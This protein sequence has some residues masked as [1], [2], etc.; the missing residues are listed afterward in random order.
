M[1][2]LKPVTGIG[3][4]L[5]FGIGLAACNGGQSSLAPQEIVNS[6]LQEA[7]EPLSYYGEYT[8]RIDSDESDATIKEWVSEDGKR[9]I[10]M[11]DEGDGSRITGVNDGESYTMYDE[12]TNTAMVMA[13]GKELQEAG[14]QTPR[15]QAERMLEMVKDTHEL[16]VGDEGKIAGRDTY[17]VIATAKDDKSLLGDQ[18]IWIDKETWMILKT[19]SKTPSG[20]L[21]VQEYTTIDYKPELSDDLF[22]FDIPEGAHIE[23]VDD[24]YAPKTATLEEA[25]DVLGTFYLVQ[26]TKDLKLAEIT[27]LDGYEGRKEFSFEYT[28]GGIPA[29]SVNVFQQNGSE[30]DF[31]GMGNDVE[32]TIRGKKGTQTSLGDFRAVDWAESGKQY[33]ALLNNPDLSFEE[34]ESYLE[35][36]E[37]VD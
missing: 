34:V 29:F 25:K 24:D 2:W 16:S 4:L 32:V 8:L 3:V 26:E 28:K 5:F 6:A 7:D 36:M 37:Q 33:N 11:E 12:S 19:I 13:G 27:V 35:A 22:A 1:N 31:G 9:R 14:Q 20:M 30:T 18:E 15:E 23:E 21:S 17:H 10:E